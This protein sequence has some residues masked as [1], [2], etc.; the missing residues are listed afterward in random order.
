MVFTR[1]WKSSRRARPRS[2]D[3]STGFSAG[4]RAGI[5]G[6]V[7]WV[8][9]RCR[10]TRTCWRRNAYGLSNHC[11]QQRR[12]SRYP[13][14]CCWHLVKQ[15]AGARVLFRDGWFKCMD[16]SREHVGPHVAEL[17]I[18]FFWRCFQRKHGQSYC[19]TAS[20]V[21]SGVLAC[22]SS[23]QAAPPPHRGGVFFPVLNI[24][25]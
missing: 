12:C 7:R 4:A 8:G 22:E 3:E 9:Q 24:A 16:C 14:C 2:D 5:H 21:C 18:S 19:R 1:R 15:P 10:A 20:R 23:S 13:S 25:Y 6:G 11:K 17:R